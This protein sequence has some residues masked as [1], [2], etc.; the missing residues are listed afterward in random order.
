MSITFEES[1]E[2]YMPVYYHFLVGFTID[3]IYAFITSDSSIFLNSK[4]NLLKY[5]I[6]IKKN[7]ILNFKGYNNESFQINFEESLGSIKIISVIPD[8]FHYCI[9]QISADKHATSLLFFIKDRD[10][11][12]ASFNSGEGIDLHKNVYTNETNKKK[13]YSPYNGRL[14]CKNFITNQIDGL[15]KILSLLIIPELYKN[16]QKSELGKNIITIP[17]KYGSSSHSSSSYLSSFSSSSTKDE[18]DYYNFEPI[19]N[20]INFLQQLIH[21]IKLKEIFFDIQI[22]GLSID[23]LNNIPNIEI[24]YDGTSPYNNDQRTGKKLEHKYIRVNSISIKQQTNSYY[25]IMTKYL[26]SFPELKL[27]TNINF[28]NNFFNIMN[29]NVKNKLILH[30]YDNDY[31]IY[32]QESGSCSWFSIYWPIVFYNIFNFDE[33]NYYQI[34]L[35]IYKKMLDY[36]NMIFNNESL[37]ICFKNNEDNFIRMKLLCEKFI[38]IKILDQELLIDQTNFIYENDIIINFQRNFQKYNVNL[39]RI[40]NIKRDISYLFENNFLIKYLERCAF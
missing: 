13:Y 38:N 16:M 25:K 17:Y 39:T 26:S 8:L 20:L 21:P 27:T 40:G 9:C 29:P 14:I 4:I 3:K 32:D 23:D 36:V 35:N 22:N 12:V 19:I 30:Y 7:I 24:Y 37:N 18:V 34:I 11:F 28:D 2:R 5:S 33:H 10:L 31:Y 1:L 15:Q 6:D